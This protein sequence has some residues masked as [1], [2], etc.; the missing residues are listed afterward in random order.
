MQPFS[1][2]LQYF[3]LFSVHENLIKTFS[4]VAHNQ[5][6]FFLFSNANQPESSPHLNSWFIKNLPPRDFSIMPLVGTDLIR[7][8]TKTIEM[9]GRAHFEFEISPFSVLNL[10]FLVVHILFKLMQFQL[11]HNLVLIFQGSHFKSF[12]PNDLSFK[13]DRIGSS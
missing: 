2:D 7:Y 10:E 13:S 1:A 3:Y 6:Q 8:A 11:S 9:R 5:P 12:K 4:K